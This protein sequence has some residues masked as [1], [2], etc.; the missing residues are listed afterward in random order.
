MFAL[1]FMVFFL[2][3]GL[4]VGA[5]QVSEVALEVRLKLQGE[6]RGVGFTPHPLLGA[7]LFLLDKSAEKD[8]VF[9]CGSCVCVCVC[10]FV[11]GQRRAL[12]S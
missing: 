6:L 3:F 2:K 5:A 7:A 8:P 1:S 11:Q 12:L 4:R 10:Q 9:C